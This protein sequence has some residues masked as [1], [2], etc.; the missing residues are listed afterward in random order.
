MRQLA[1]HE[2]GHGYNWTRECILAMDLDEMD[3]H[4]DWANQRRKDI[5]AAQKRAAKAK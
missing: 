2:F 1:W 3:R 4:I 5:H